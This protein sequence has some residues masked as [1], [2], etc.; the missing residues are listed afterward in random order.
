MLISLHRDDDARDLLDRVLAARKDIKPDSATNAYRGERMQLARTYS[1]FLTYAPRTLLESNSEEATE[2][3]GCKP[4]TSPVAKPANC[5]ES[6][7]IQFDQDATL[8]F[9]RYLSL[10]LFINA[11]KSPD[12]PAPLRA[13][14]AIVAWVRSVQLD[15]KA[16]AKEL[17]P[18]LPVPVQKSAGDSTGFP[19][20]LALLRNPGLRPYLEAGVSRIESYSSLSDFRDNWWCVSE[21]TQ[22]PALPDGSPKPTAPP[23]TFLTDEQKHAG[24]AQFQTLNQLPCGP[25]YLG[26]R[27]LAYAKSNPTDPSVPE[28]LAL[29]VRATRYGR[30]SY[31]DTP[32]TKQKTEVSKAAFQLLHTRYPKSPWTAKTPYYY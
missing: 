8:I 22:P 18:L 10:D 25:I 30:S 15:D 1:E 17:S 14:I 32:E 5:L 31:G 3:E 11:A 20:T 2:L 16:A 26:Q 4:A 7:P 12:L 23:L 21:V 24:N 9:N 13:K 28:A 27:V 6:S 29:T 19:A